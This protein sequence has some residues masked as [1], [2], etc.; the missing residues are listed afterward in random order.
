MKSDGTGKPGENREKCIF[1]LG[2]RLSSI[3]QGL[4]ERN[5]ATFSSDSSL[6]MF[7]VFCLIKA[8]DV[9]SFWTLRWGITGTSALGLL[10]WAYERHSKA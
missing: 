8:F 10:K 9:F 4:K 2:V 1:S 6:N 7:G 5:Y 3:V